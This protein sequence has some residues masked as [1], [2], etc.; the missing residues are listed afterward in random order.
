MNLMLASIL[1]P[2]VLGG[3]CWL[4]P[5]RNRW[6][7]E[8]FTVAAALLPLAAGIRFLIAAPEPVLYGE[9]ILLKADALS[10]FMLPI[11]G[12]AGLLLAIYSFAF[13]SRQPMK[14]TY[15]SAFCWTLG[16]AAG[17]LLANHLLLVLF[18]WGI[19]ALTLTLLILTGQDSAESARKALIII[20]GSDALLLLGIFC[21]YTISKSFEMDH[22]SILLN[23]RLAVLAFL[24]FAAAAFAKAGAIPLHTWIPD[25]SVS[26]P[27]PATALM[28]AAL[29][30]ILGIY[31]LARMVLNLFVMTK[32]F[33]LF[34]LILGSI[35]IIAAVM[36]ALVQHD[37]K[38]LLAYHAISQVG[39]MIVGLGTGNPIGLA[40]ALFHMLNNVV[41]KTGLFLAG[42]VVEQQTGTTDLD[43]LGGIGRRMPWTFGTFMICALAISGIP[44]LNGFVS[45]WM[46]YQGILQIP[47]SWGGLWVIWITAA[48]FGSGLTLASFMKLSHAVFLGVP[49]PEIEKKPL[50]EPGFAFL[51]PLIVLALLCIGLGL[52]FR[53]YPLTPLKEILGAIQAEGVWSPGTATVMI[54]I[55][56]A[57]GLLFYAFGNIKTG[58][59]KADTFI[60]GE[61][62][63]PAAR[64]TGTAFYETIRNLPLINT[65]YAWTEARVFDL[66]DQGIRC[67]QWTAN[68]FR[69][70]HNGVLTLY[71]I[72]V[73][74]GLAVLLWIFGR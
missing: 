67:I 74:A 51:F 72:W 32:A 10:R 4:V 73:L 33:G 70:A 49:S 18:F 27:V 45:K 30:K 52:F 15:Y 53:I 19:L 6:L 36:R 50:K 44:P 57:A 2:M 56:I 55:G 60:G 59:R 48:M 13:M 46:I 7:R 16:A 64:L 58:L 21:I 41:Y 26:A 61:K 24:C 12:L 17:V 37:L 63:P 9:T 42:G 68:W 71:L 65:F 20:G 14:S 38:Q 8:I 31:L 1:I 47:D 66:Y 43:K 39:Y 28:P 69:K 25:M 3:L 40:G 34:L 35:T 5:G 23:H 22:I 29:D 11:A 54:L 62:L